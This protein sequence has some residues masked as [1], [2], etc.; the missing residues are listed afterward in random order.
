[1]FK[2]QCQKFKKMYIWKR[3][4][5]GQI[6]NVTKHILQLVLW[7]FPHSETRFGFIFLWCLCL[8]F[9]IWSWSCTV[10]Q[11][12]VGSTT[13]R[14]HG[15][16]LT[17]VTRTT[18]TLPVGCCCCYCLA[19]NGRSVAPL[20][21]RLTARL[22]RSGG[23]MLLSVRSWST[24]LL[25]ERPGRRRHRL[26]GGR[27]SDRLMWQLSALWAVTSSGSLATWPKRALRR[28]LMVSEMDGRPVVG[29]LS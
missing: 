11:S 15:D 16:Q 5:T 26:L 2:T 24:H 20:W 17:V 29:W 7:Q 18:P 1:M 19:G 22:Q 28:W 27:S 25:R 8:V 23:G 13:D 10:V 21:P 14:S 6:T 12:L 9:V 3:H 4:N